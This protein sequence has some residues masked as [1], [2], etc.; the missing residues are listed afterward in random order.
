MLSFITSKSKK[1]IRLPIFLSCIVFVL[2]CYSLF[3]SDQNI[4]KALQ[5]QKMIS[6]LG[7]NINIR[8]STYLKNYSYSLNLSNKWAASL[9]Q[10]FQRF[11]SSNNL[12]PPQSPPTWNDT[13]EDIRSKTKD[14]LSKCQEKDDFFGN[15]ENPTIDS[16]ILPYAQWENL[17]YKTMNHLTFYQHISTN[18]EIR[19]AS[20]EAESLIDKYSIESGL[21]EDVF[22]NV[23]KVYEATKDNSTLSLELKRYIF[24]LY[25]GY[26]RNGLESPKETREK[27]EKVSKELSELSITYNKNL[28]EQ[29]EFLLFTK[30]ELKGLPDSVL[31]Q[32]KI[33]EDGK[34]KVTFKYPDIVPTMKYASN[35]ETRKRAFL[36]DQNKV[37]GNSELLKKAISKRTELANYLGYSTFAEYVLEDSMAK[38]S[39]TV[40]NFENDLLKK[41]QPKAKEELKVL[42]ELKKKDYEQQGLTFD[43]K[44]Y[45]W[46]N[47]YYNNKL[48]Q[49][50]YKVNEEKISEYF[51]LQS[52]VEKMLGFYETLFNLKFQQLADSD[53][54]VWHEDVKQFVVWKMD[55]PENPEFTGYIY[56]D[57]HPRDGKY[58]HAAEFGIYPGFFDQDANNKSRPVC[59]LVCNFSKPSKNKPSLLKHSEVTTFFHELGHGIHELVGDTYFARFHG[60]N[61]ARDFVEAPSQMLE[62][63]TWSPNELRKLSSHYATGET[64]S[65]E[66]IQSLVDSKHVN[67]GL[68]NLR[69]LHFGLFD[70]T[71]HNVQEGEAVDI[72]D[73]WNNLREKICMLNSGGEITKGYG[74]FGHMMGGYAAGYYGYLYSEVF[75][76]DMFYTLF[77]D[78]PMN[79]FNGI[80]YRDL[81]LKR[82]GSRDEIENIKELLNREPNSDA[83]L[84][85]IGV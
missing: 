85:E 72:D 36:G 5:L 76:T 45:L 58:G 14:F 26:K 37:S 32:F 40:L 80:R 6:S 52:T 33:M 24:K 74:S 44:Y 65:D 22:N 55:D 8:C 35:P 23:K 28:G 77:K 15:L 81:I 34:Y 64:L 19:D 7:K 43:G 47:A 27:I 62:F 50:N 31:E 83:F 75:A 20:T 10:N 78:D 21:R 17:K 42:L 53:K 13:P 51:P 54:Q 3:K 60:T 57:L 29:T 73:A 9:S 56:F 48:L 79:S 2:V 71:I 69:Q 68:F 1:L 46:D 39:A 30:E 11:M 63:W 49:E 38:D 59:S 67:G 16:L 41:L 12:V 70:M 84:K 82:G 18:S 25:N 61:T 4:S 66:L